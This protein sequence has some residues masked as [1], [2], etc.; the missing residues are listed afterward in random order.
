MNSLRGQVEA[1]LSVRQREI[2]EL[3]DLL[4]HLQ[5][6][7][8]TTEASSGQTPIE[9]LRIETP[10]VP[11]TNQAPVTQGIDVRE[12]QLEKPRTPWWKFRLR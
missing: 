3:R 11:L 6:L 8:P 9:S 4:R 5:T 10:V 1:Q 2:Q 7:A 12:A